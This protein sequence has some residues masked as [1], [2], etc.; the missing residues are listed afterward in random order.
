MLKVV[1]QDRTRSASIKN[2][3]STNCFDIIFDY[4]DGLVGGNDN[5]AG[6]KKG[7]GGI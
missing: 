4:Q 7:C 6:R 3:G 5:F 1:E 2:V